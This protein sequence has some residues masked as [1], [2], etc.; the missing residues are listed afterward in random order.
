M[1]NGSS[2]NILYYLTFQQM[3]FGRDQVRLVCSPLVGFGGMKV[4]FVGTITLLVLVF[5][6]LKNTIGLT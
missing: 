5:R 2:A 1:D 3:R 6:P 4:Q